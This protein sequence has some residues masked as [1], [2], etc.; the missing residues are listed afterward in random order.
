MHLRKS[1]VCRNTQGKFG[2]LE[3]PAAAKAA[4]TASAKASAAAAPAG[5]AGPG[6]GA[7]ARGSA[8]ARGPAGK[9]AAADPAAAGAAALAHTAAGPGGHTGPGRRPGRCAG[10]GCSR[11]RR[12]GTSRA[13]CGPV[14]IGPR[15]RTAG[16]GAGSGRRGRTMPHPVIPRAAG[17]MPGEDRGKDHSGSGHSPIVTIPASVSGPLDGGNNEINHQNNQDNT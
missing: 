6:G 13:G 15:S 8:G 14:G 7:G 17:P 11:E 10:T 12:T 9:A 1:P 4:A 16:S 3:L 5:T 2:S